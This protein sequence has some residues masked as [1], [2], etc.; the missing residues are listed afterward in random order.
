[1]EETYPIITILPISNWR[2]TTW[3]IGDIKENTSRL[4]SIDRAKIMDKLE[5]VNSCHCRTCRKNKID[6][7]SW[8]FNYLDKNMEET[9]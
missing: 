5:F 2:E 3:T 1:M 6:Y 7:L 4:S 8:L 9:K